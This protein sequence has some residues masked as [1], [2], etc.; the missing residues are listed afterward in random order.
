MRAAHV[1][2]GAAAN[3]MCHQL[4][5]TA[6]NLESSARECHEAGETSAPPALQQLVHQHFLEMQQAFTN[7]SQF[8]QS[9][10]I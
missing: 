5:L 1:I 10:G 6:L 9:I 8:L 2:K 7:F 3:L 4:R